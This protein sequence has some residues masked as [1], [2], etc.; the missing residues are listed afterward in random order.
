MPSP[1][2]GIK[3]IHA[4]PDPGF[5]HPLGSVSP[6]GSAAACG[7]FGAG[8]SGARRRPSGL[9]RGE[10]RW[11]QRN[12]RCD[13]C[14]R[15]RR[16]LPR[17]CLPGSLLFPATGLDPDGAGRPLL[18]ISQVLSPREPLGELPEP[19]PQLFRRPRPPCARSRESGP[20]SPPLGRAPTPLDRPGALRLRRAQS[21]A[22]DTQMVPRRPLS[23]TAN[24]HPPTPPPPPGLGSYLLEGPN[25]PAGTPAPTWA[26]RGPGTHLCWISGSSL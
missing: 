14:L 17:P 4:F 1:S 2:L 15:S 11:A 18:V 13:S 10:S 9:Q 5:E 21:R 25:P 22:R 3:R 16:R 12:P 19:A 6:R 24:P 8:A 7:G 20:R 26:L 23:H